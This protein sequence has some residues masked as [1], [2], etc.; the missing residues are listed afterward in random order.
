MSH[1]WNG[2]LEIA[3][4]ELR[5]LNIH[6]GLEWTQILDKKH[7]WSYLQEKKSFFEP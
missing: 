5:V 7:M 6:H 2:P 4:T 1:K 3:N